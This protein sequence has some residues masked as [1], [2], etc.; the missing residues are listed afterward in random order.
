VAR[1]KTDLA[2]L[3][4]RV[5]YTFRDAELLSLALTHMSSS[6]A[7]ERGHYQRLEFLGDRVLGLAVAEFV[8]RAYPKAAEGELSRRFSEVVRRESC[9]AVARDWDAGSYLWLGTGESS[10]GGRANTA[11]LADVCEAIL[12]AVFL[13]GGYEAARTVIDR[14]FRERVTAAAAA[15]RRDAKT[16][17]QEWAQAQGL[18]TPVYTVAEQS[19]PQHAPQFRVSAKVRG[20]D[21]AFGAGASKRA[22]EQDAAQN[23]LVREGVWRE[24][25]SDGNS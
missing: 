13:D 7:G 3:E 14:A 4:E 23:L 8:Y 1:R 24:E 12:G 5:G 2:A 11:I 10:S 20:F 21:K 18:P 25:A 6:N 9:A 16:E 17:L 15:Q 22:A 19:G